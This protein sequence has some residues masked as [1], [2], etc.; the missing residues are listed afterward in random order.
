MDLPAGRT[1]VVEPRH[2]TVTTPPEQLVRDALRN[3]VAGP[4]LREVVRPG[5]RV[6]ISICDGTRPQPR[7]L[8]LTAIFAEL[9]GIVAPDDVTIMV[10]T[11]THRGNTDDELLA[12]LGK[13]ILGTYRVVNHDA[14]DESTLVWRGRHGADVP[15]WLARDWVEADVRLTTGFVEPHFFAGF[16]GGRARRAGARGAGDR[17][18]AARRPA[19]RGP[20]GDLGDL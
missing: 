6:A 10:A 19:D 3:P 13:E 14:R 8:M 11:G 2:L 15:V 17:P 7:E 12:M 1:T 5:Q 4:P 9:D 16:S 20:E 18:D